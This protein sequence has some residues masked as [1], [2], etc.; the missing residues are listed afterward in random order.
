MNITKVAAWSE[1]VSSIAVLATLVYLAL[2]MQ[3]N[4]AAVRADTRQAMIAADIGVL[5]LYVDNPDL[6]LDGMHERT[7][8]PEDK[9]RLH[10]ATTLFLRTREHNWFQYQN[11]VLDEV[12]FAS[13]ANP[14]SSILGTERMRK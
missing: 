12:T 2:Q 3:Q 11:G 8:T 7:L 4:T 6:W 14:I 5:S 10:M 9:V 13:Y 1:I